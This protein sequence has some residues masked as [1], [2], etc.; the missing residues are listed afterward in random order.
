MVY[1][2]KRLLLT[3]VVNERDILTVLQDVP[4]CEILCD[5]GNWKHERRPSWEGYHGKAEHARDWPVTGDAVQLHLDSAT[6]SP[7]HI[8]TMPGKQLRSGFITLDSLIEIFE[9]FHRERILNC[10]S[11]VFVWRTVRD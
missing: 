10:I 7:M 4:A 1:S 5:N 8:L 3:T 9:S 6:S 2:L 11:S